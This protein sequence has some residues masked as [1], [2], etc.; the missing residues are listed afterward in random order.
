MLFVKFCLHINSIEVNNRMFFYILLVTIL[1]L[2]VIVCYN[3][4]YKLYSFVHYFSYLLVYLLSTGNIFLLV[5]NHHYMVLL[6]L[7]FLWL[8]L[9]SL[10]VMCLL[11]LLSLGVWHGYCNVLLIEY[12]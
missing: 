7:Q 10:D 9:I 12:V 1:L 4:K 3:C 8:I 5:K 2:F 6:D 11:F